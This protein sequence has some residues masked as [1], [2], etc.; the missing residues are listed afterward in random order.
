MR[1]IIGLALVA[2][3]VAMAVVIGN[4]MSTDAM[5]VVIGVVFGVAAS[6]PTSLLV[7][8]ASRRSERPTPSYPREHNTQAP[9]QINI[10]LGG[11]GMPV[12]DDGSLPRWPIEQWQL[13]QPAPR[14]FQIVGDE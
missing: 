13:G 2:G 9:P 4:R 5:A 10:H 6:I 1:W 7:I 11:N 3:A 12:V 14:E 8:A